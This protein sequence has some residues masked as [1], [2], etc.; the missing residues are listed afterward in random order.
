MKNI[1]KTAFTL[2]FTLGVSF[3]EAQTTHQVCVSEPEDNVCGGTGVFFPNQLTINVGDQIEFTTYYVAV[4]G[5]TGTDH[6][7]EFDGSPANNVTLPVSSDLFNQ[8]TSVTTPPFNTPG[9]F[10]IECTNF[11]HCVLATS[12][13]TGYS[14]TVVGAGCDVVAGFTADDLEV[15]QGTT[16]SFTNTSTDATDYEWEIDG[17]SYSTDTDPTYTFNTTGTFEITLI[18]SD[19]TCDDTFSETITVNQTPTATVTVSPLFALMG[20]EVSVSFTTDGANPNTTYSWDLCDGSNESFTTDFNYSWSDEGSYCVCLMLTNEN[21]CE[22]TNCSDDEV[23]VQGINSLQQES[24]ISALMNVY[25]N[26]SNGEFTVELLNQSAF[27]SLKLIDT[28]GSELLGYEKNEIDESNPKIEVHL[29][30]SGTYT[31]IIETITG[32]VYGYPIVVTK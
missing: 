29:L 18:A 6:T 31:V 4:S 10:P 13:C 8:V 14:V 22:S 26:P 5:Y 27:K 19:G 9:T 23:Q 16:V 21:G 11:N 32:E 25:P 7:I 30:K 20:E 1:Y 28:K 2:I 24:E 12:S 17:T 3:L 15:C